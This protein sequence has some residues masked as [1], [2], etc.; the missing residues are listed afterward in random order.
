[1]KRTAADIRKSE[2]AMIHMA[3]AQLG[4][5]D[6]TYRS[7]LENVTKTSSNPGKR[8]AADLDDADRKKVIE[9]LKAKGFKVSKKGVRTMRPAPDKAELIAKIRAQLITADNKPDSYA[10]GM[11]KRMFKVDRYEWCNPDQL[12]KIVQALAVDARRKA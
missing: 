8:S 9:H 11:A 10:D 1:M 12:H 7:M 4:M 5:D 3:K 2:L 6:D